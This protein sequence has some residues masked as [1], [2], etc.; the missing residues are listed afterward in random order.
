[1]LPK[2]RENQNSIINNNK[3]I[4]KYLKIGQYISIHY[5]SQR[6]NLME[7]KI[8][9]DFNVNNNKTSKNV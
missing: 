8:Y 1:M 3:E 7:T 9:F 6:A 4:L 2:Q 5:K